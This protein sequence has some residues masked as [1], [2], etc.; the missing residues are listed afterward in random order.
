MA[1][2]SPRVWLGLGALII[3]ALVVW[4]AIALPG[5]GAGRASQDLLN[6]LTLGSLYALIALGYT[7]VYGILRMINFAHG[8]IFMLG[9][10]FAFYAMTL[11][12]LPLT[13]ALGAGLVAGAIAF[14]LWRDAPRQAALLA[15]VIFLLIT[16]GLAV[17][18]GWIGALLISMALTG[19]AGTALEAVAYRPLRGAPRESLLITA[20]AAS[21]FLQNAGQL[22]FGAQVQGF[23]PASELITPRQST[24][25]GEP[26]FY[27]NLVLLIPIATALLLVIFHFF[28]TRSRLGKAMRATAQDS[29]AALMM[30]IQVYQVIRV[31]F[32]L[33]S[34]LAAV[35][36]VFYAM[37]FGQINPLMGLLPG[38]KA[39]AAA[40]IGG[41]GSLPG[42]VLG[43]FLL[44]GVE[45]FAVSLFPTLSAYR[46]VFAFGILVLILLFLPSGLLGESRGE[47]V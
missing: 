46:D 27:T 1:K 26:I 20:I 7:L 38:I 15:G 35:A 9:A 16:F 43:G 12:P 44:G 28:V 31:T 8:E 42:A 4:R 37:R 47:K 6:A 5:Y 34:L 39:F 41:I 33:G 2:V 14:F 17:P 23:R 22:V 11:A 3:L 13:G 24:V 36:G 45:I 29:E 21:F 30:C 25:F 10:F 19:L 40:V 32:F 18:F